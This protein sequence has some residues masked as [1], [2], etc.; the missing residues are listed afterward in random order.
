MPKVQKS[1][2]GD[3]VEVWQVE[4]RPDLDPV[5]VEGEYSGTFLFCSIKLLF[6]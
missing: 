4:D 3:T 6:L 1:P 2:M 5:K